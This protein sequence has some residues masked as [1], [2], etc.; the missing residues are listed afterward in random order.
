MNNQ[1]YYA[2]YVCYDGSY[3][4]HTKEEFGF[5]VATHDGAFARAEQVDRD[6]GQVFVIRSK[7][8]PGQSFGTITAARSGM[9][10]QQAWENVADA[11]SYGNLH[12]WV[13]GDE[14]AS[15]VFAHEPE[16]Y[17]ILGGGTRA[18]W[19]KMLDM[20]VVEDRKVQA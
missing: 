15:W 3:E 20:G 6:G 14:S 10:E 9:T 11:V 8:G 18:D 4:T 1:P 7:K 12:E 13:G 16:F 2:L 5:A 17:F 19:Q